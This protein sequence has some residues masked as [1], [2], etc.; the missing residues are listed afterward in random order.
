MNAGMTTVSEEHKLGEKCLFPQEHC[1]PTHT[2]IASFYIAHVKTLFLVLN[3]LFPEVGF[4][5][6]NQNHCI[7]FIKD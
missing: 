5:K 3:T 7:M 2:Y 1:S 4:I 6:D